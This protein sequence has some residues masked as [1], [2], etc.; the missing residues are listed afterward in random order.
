M[1]WETSSPMAS[2]SFP[3]Y[4]FPPKVPD[5]ASLSNEVWLESYKL[6]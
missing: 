3:V 6:K 5:L 2:E 4:M 1:S